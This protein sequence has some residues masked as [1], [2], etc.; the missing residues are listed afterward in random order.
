M[1]IE[2][3]GRRWSWFSSPKYGELC[4]YSSL[5]PR[6]LRQSQAHSSSLVLVSMSAAIPARAA[7]CVLQVSNHSI[8]DER[9]GRN[10]GLSSEKWNG[11][12]WQYWERPEE[13]RSGKSGLRKLMSGDED[14]HRGEKGKRRALELF[15]G[16][17]SSTWETKEIK[18]G[19]AV[20]W[21]EGLLFIAYASERAWD[22]LAFRASC[23]RQH[24]LMPRRIRGLG[25]RSAGSPSACLL[26]FVSGGL[27]SW[28]PIHVVWLRLACDLP[29]WCWPCHLFASLATTLNFGHRPKQLP[30]L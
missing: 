11:Q 9:P 7:G 4:S 2:A 3:D 29:A 20:W 27:G 6:G 8:L 25:G 23:H 10:P 21:S 17:C 13:S 15:V 1:W 18:E 19:W 26:C 16:K 28:F 30:Q 14:H 5:C 12:G 22:N 24:L